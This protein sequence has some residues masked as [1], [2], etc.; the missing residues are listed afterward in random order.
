VLVL[1]LD[2]IRVR[3]LV[4]VVVLGWWIEAFPQD[5]RVSDGVMQW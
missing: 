3:V 1:V 2:L 4:L 5:R